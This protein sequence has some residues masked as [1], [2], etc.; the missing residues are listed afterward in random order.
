MPASV[1]CTK[2]FLQSFLYSK[3][4]S[5]NSKKASE[6]DIFALFVLM[7]PSKAIDCNSVFLMW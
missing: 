2:L 5:D 7:D 3:K 4:A 6:N 1:I